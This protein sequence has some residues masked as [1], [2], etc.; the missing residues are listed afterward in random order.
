MAPP[1]K[2]TKAAVK[3]IKRAHSFQTIPPMV[4]VLFVVDV[5]GVVVDVDVVVVVVVTFVATV[6]VGKNKRK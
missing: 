3:H 6:V 4:V 2:T 1:T 5:G